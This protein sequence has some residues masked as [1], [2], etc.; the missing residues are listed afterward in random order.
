MTT[1]HLSV[2]F[3]EI[4]ADL[5]LY[6]ETLESNEFSKSKK[7][8]V[9]SRD[10]AKYCSNSLAKHFWAKSLSILDPSQS[11]SELLHDV[12]YSEFIPGYR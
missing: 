6:Q 1:I 7:R 2:E 11:A 5:S 8:M 12:N 3:F 9:A 4:K 10:S